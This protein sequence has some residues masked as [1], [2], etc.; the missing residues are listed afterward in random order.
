MYLTPT[1]YKQQ[2]EV[3]CINNYAVYLP[4][5]YQILPETNVMTRC[6]IVGNGRNKQSVSLPNSIIDSQ[7]NDKHQ[8]QSTCKNNFPKEKS[9]D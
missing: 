2:H 1:H 6:Y 8:Q 5:C 7:H 3:L 9:M 4:T